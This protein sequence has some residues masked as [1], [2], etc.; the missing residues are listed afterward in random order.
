LLK[1]YNSV[2]THDD[3]KE[4]LNVLKALASAKRKKA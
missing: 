2:D 4:I 3:R 1:I